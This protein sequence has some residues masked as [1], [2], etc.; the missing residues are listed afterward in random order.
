MAKFEKGKS[1]N[2]AGMPVGTVHSSSIFRSKVKEAFL[3]NN[4]NPILE[5]MR[6]GMDEN[7]KPEL[8]FGCNKE[9]AKYYVPQLK[10]IELSQAKENPLKFVINIEKPSNVD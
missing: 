3:D 6:M 10:S 8:R 2:P 7:T 5:M 9:L 4:Y 1:G